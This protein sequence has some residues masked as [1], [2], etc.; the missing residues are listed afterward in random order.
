MGKGGIGIYD[1]DDRLNLQRDEDTTETFPS[2]LPGSRPPTRGADTDG[3]GGFTSPLGGTMSPTKDAVTASSNLSRPST[4]GDR[5]SRPSTAA[6]SSTMDSMDE[7]QDDFAAMHAASKAGRRPAS[8]DSGGGGGGGTPQQGQRQQ[9]GPVAEDPD[10][11]EAVRR[12]WCV[13]DTRRERD[14]A[15]GARVV[16][17]DDFVRFVALLNRVT[18]AGASDANASARAAEEQWANVLLYKAYLLRRAR[19]AQ[20]HEDAGVDAVLARMDTDGDGDVDRDDDKTRIRT[21]D[22][23]ALL[24][25]ARRTAGG[26]GGL[27][28]FADFLAFVVD[29]AGHAVFARQ[30]SAYTM[31]VD[32]PY[33]MVNLV[34]FRVVG[35][36]GAL[37]VIL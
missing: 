21:E 5:S 8:R 32:W 37:Q 14:R 1:D 13:M 6:T 15:T 26:H 22:R 19:R 12:M 4:A 35:C 28:A 2:T 30:A 16:R 24:E 23:R 36:T 34:L 10:V 17:R 3:G 9:E 33:T 20:G 11:K 31:H 7:S 27:L 29:L 18:S 25:W